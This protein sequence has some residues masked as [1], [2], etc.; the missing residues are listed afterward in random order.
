V[1]SSTIISSWYAGFTGEIE[2]ADMAHTA[3]TLVHR[4]RL[5]DRQCSP[6]HRSNNA[7]ATQR[8]ELRDGCWAVSVHR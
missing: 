2:L 8:E 6:T 1:R 5:G 3:M 7:H 4:Y